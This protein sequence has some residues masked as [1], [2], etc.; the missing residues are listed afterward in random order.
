MSR[1][2]I[3]VSVIIPTYNRAHCVGEAI[4]SVLAQVPPANEVIVVDD[5]ST[6]NTVEVLAGYGDRIIILHQDNAG[7]AAARNTG[8]RH[9]TSE[10]VAFL[11]SDDLWYPGRMAVLHRDLA[12]ADEDIVGHTGDMRFTG[13]KQDLRL[14]DLR[15]WQ[16]SQG[17]AERVT[18]IILKGM[19]GLFSIATAL[20][21]VNV[22]EEGGYRESLRIYEDVALFYSLALRGPWLFTG[23]ILA[24]SR[25]LPDDT[26]PLS[27]I[28]RNHPVEAAN[29]KVQFMSALL[30]RDLS[31][32]QRI[33][34]M[35]QTSGALLAL[36]AAEAAENTGSHR[37]TAIASAR[38][39][40][41]ALNGWLKALPPLLLGRIGY[42][43]SLQRRKAFTRS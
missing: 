12:D 13:P 14:F 1:R 42:Q 28:E 2:A 35:K 27:T 3:T 10:W 18:N 36:A 33:L 32:E 22:L 25:R 20:R 16:F 19:T 7:A 17:K 30:D 31:P 29:G 5:G 23:D 21:R 11:D 41:S 38:Q 43:I 4:D 39:H 24:E 34:I 26:D 6:D 9:A 37:R 8:I 15:G 40:P